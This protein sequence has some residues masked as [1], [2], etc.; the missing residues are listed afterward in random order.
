M[1]FRLLVSVRI[2]HRAYCMRGII[3][4]D[5]IFR[6]ESLKTTYV[7]VSKSLLFISEET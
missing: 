5:Q 2:F 1:K 7:G 4:S 6:I 3:K